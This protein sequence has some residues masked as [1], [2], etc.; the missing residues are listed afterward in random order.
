MWRLRLKSLIS[1]QETTSFRLLPCLPPNKR[2]ASGARLTCALF[3][4]RRYYTSSPISTEAISVSPRHTMC[5]WMVGS[6]L[7]ELYRQCEAAG[8]PCT[9]QPYGSEIQ[10]RSGKL[11]CFTYV[12]PH[13]YNLARQ[14]MYYLVCLDRNARS[15]GMLRRI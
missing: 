13:T 15:L 9:A 2:D 11:F 10:H 6:E 5:S 3:Q 12:V 7:I 4:Y 14:T 1:L 8:A